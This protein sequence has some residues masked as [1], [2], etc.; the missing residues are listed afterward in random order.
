MD[1][2]ALSEWKC[3]WLHRIWS[4][5]WNR[6]V[7]ETL[8]PHPFT[9]IYIHI[10]SS[11]VQIY[12]YKRM[13]IF[14]FQHYILNTMS[15]VCFVHKGWVTVAPAWACSTETNRMGCKQN[16]GVPLFSLWDRPNVFSLARENKY[17]Q[18]D[19]EIQVR[20]EVNLTDKTKLHKL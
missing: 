11:I 14:Q 9:Y 16:I 8:H 3:T 7:W 17:K 15:S 2:E 6:R 12:T 19:K 13:Q 5:F 10:N 18:M 1:N 4:H 20:F